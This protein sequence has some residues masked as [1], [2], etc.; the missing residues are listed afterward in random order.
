MV[1]DQFGRK[2]TDRAGHVVAVVIVIFFGGQHLHPV[3]VDKLG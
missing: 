2:V 3:A 1:D